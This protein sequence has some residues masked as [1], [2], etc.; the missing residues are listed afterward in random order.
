MENG[1]MY[2]GICINI[3]LEEIFE[4]RCLVFVGFSFFISVL[5]ILMFILK[6]DIR[7]CL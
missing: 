7:L 5:R 1:V 3:C 2:F 4:L 6:G